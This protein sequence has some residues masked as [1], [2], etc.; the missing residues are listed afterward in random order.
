MPQAWSY[1]RR[2]I[3]KFF[4]GFL[5]LL[6]LMLKENGW[7]WHISTTRLLMQGAIARFTICEALVLPQENFYAI[8][9]SGNIVLQSL[10]KWSAIK[11]G[12][13]GS[14][15]KLLK[16]VSAL[17]TSWSDLVTTKSDTDCKCFDI[18]NDRLWRSVLPCFFT[19][20]F[21]AWETLKCLW[22]SLQNA[23]LLPFSLFVTQVNSISHPFW[24]FDL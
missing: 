18:F 22:Q 10:L 3:T 1:T 19:S 24:Y 2:R 12:W 4:S 13:L 9:L 16:R 15:I 6:S 20:F 7:D 14:A 17:I 5:S 23:K 11:N 8:L 21:P